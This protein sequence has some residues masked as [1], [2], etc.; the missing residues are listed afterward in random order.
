MASRWDQINYLHIDWWTLTGK[1]ELTQFFDWH[2]SKRAIHLINKHNF[3]FIN[4]RYGVHRVAEGV[5]AHDVNRHL[6]QTMWPPTADRRFV[7]FLPLWQHEHSRAHP[8]DT[9]STCGVF[10]AT[11][12]VRHYDELIMCNYGSWV[13]AGSVPWRDVDYARNRTN[14]FL[15]RFVVLYILCNFPFC[16]RRSTHVLFAHNLGQR[17]K[18]IRRNDGKRSHRGLRIQRADWEGKGGAAAT[19]QTCVYFIEMVSSVGNPSIV[20]D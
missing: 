15:D 3:F 2:R 17:T 10:G 9:I 8:T 7:S 1:N 14:L 4:G 12:A 6:H 5:V 18:N 20:F 19:A 16:A 11:A 13:L